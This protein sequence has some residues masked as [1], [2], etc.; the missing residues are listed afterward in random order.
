M[1]IWMGPNKA[2]QLF[3]EELDI[4]FTGCQWDWQPVCYFFSLIC[5]IIYTKS[6]KG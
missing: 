2:I 5:G 3:S 6:F 1:L 4:R